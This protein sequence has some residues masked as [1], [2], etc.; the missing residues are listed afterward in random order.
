VK[1]EFLQQIFEKDSNIK[2]LETPSFGSQVIPC[3]WTEGHTDM[4]KLVVAFHNFANL[5]KNC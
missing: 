5:L 1:L 4:T 2:F 3:G